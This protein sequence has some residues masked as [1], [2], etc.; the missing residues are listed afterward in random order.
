MKDIFMMSEISPT[1][2]TTKPTPRQPNTLF[3]VSFR[4]TPSVRAC[5]A[6]HDDMARVQ[7]LGLPRIGSTERKELVIGNASATRVAMR[8]Q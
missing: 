1:Q 7:S 6:L 2:I 8:N 5:F 3:I 4:S